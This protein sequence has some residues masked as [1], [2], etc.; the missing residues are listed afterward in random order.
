MPQTIP[1]LLRS[2]PHALGRRADARRERRREEW[3]RLAGLSYG[4]F[5]RR[6]CLHMVRLLNFIPLYFAMLGLISAVGFAI[7]TQMPAA[8][9]FDPVSWFA[10]AT[11]FS[12]LGIQW[13]SMKSGGE[14][15]VFVLFLGP[16]LFGAMIFFLFLLFFVPLQYWVLK[17]WARGERER[18][19]GT[20]K[21]PSTWQKIT[22]NWFV[23]LVLFLGPI[24][25]G[26]MSFLLFLLFFVPLQ[27][28]VLKNWARGE[29]ERLAGTRK[30]SSTGRKITFTWFVVLWVGVLLHLWLIR[31]PVQG[32]P[33]QPPPEHMGPPQAYFW[34]QKQPWPLPE[35]LPKGR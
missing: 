24:L 14:G 10:E 15:M 3:R 5:F 19:A 6:Q 32:P 34:W 1:N 26:A 33:F 29:R 9:F 28:W 4:A 8:V 21:E 30:E 35:S 17:N 31:Y 27:G 7:G 22:L 13:W 11:F 25:F 16:I 23:V 12:S 18:L 2:M 20:R